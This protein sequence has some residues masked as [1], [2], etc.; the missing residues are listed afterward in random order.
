MSTIPE[1][2]GPCSGI[3]K[4]EYKVKAT[5]SN[6][7]SDSKR[8]REMRL[9]LV[10]R[11]PRQTPAPAGVHAPFHKPLIG[12]SNHCVRM[13]GLRQN[14]GSRLQ[15]A[16]SMAISI[17]VCTAIQN[18]LVNMLPEIHS[19]GL[20][21]LRREDLGRALQDI[22]TL[23]ENF[24]WYGEAPN[25]HDPERQLTSSSPDGHCDSKVCSR[26]CFARCCFD[27]CLT[28]KHP[29][30]KDR[31]GTISVE[32]HWYTEDRSGNRISRVMVDQ[33]QVCGHQNARRFPGNCRIVTSPFIGCANAA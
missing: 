22:K 26:S 17:A 30:V 31:D 1:D 24:E 33:Q 28:H 23:G 29:S 3:T 27:W 6:F 18:G 25:P 16:A 19:T 10:R 2:Q 14:T 15:S 7:V 13:R 9:S 12:S 32:M 8:G 20:K 11:G 4:H 21:C 5:S